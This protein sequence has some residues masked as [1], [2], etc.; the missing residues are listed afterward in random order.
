MSKEIN[1]C[2]CCNENTTVTICPKNNKC[3]YKLCDNCISNL[4]EKTKTN[5][6]PACR[7]VIFVEEVSLEI[8][9]EESEESEESS[10]EN[11]QRDTSNSN[12]DICVCNCCVC[13]MPNNYITI[14]EYCCCYFIFWPC[15]C[16][17]KY[18]YNCN[19]MIECIFTTYNI[20]KKKIRIPLNIIFGITLHGL[21]ILLCR[22]IY[23]LTL[24]KLYQEFFCDI[25]QFFLTSG[26]GFFFLFLYIIL[27][28]VCGNICCKCWC[29]EEDF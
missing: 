2:D 22:F 29:T 10:D 18:L 19:E 6:C 25:E 27:T 7:E 20:E 23:L 14:L 17:T 15:I 5:Q 8:S 16:I 21:F 11:E 4:K 12:E 1:E 9:S 13:I 24:N 26:V 28:F 3:E